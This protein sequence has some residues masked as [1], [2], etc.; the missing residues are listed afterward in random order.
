M[1]WAAR[2]QTTR[3]E[4]TAYCLLGIF[5]VNMPLLYGE[6]SK[7]FLRFQEEIMKVSTDLSILLWQRRASSM[8]GMLAAAPSSFDKDGRNPLDLPRH[9]TLFH[10]TRGWTTNNAGTDLQLHIY[11]YLLTHDTRKIFLACV[12]ELNSLWLAE[13]GIFLEELNEFNGIEVRATS[14]YRRATVDG[15]AWIK[16]ELPSRIQNPQLSLRR[17]FITRHAPLNYRTTDGISGF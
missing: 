1:A 3:E 17:L 16:V 4:D 5:N 7:A 6:G 8:N 12:H 9:K 11:P 2:R 13:Y 14:S 10:I 15:D